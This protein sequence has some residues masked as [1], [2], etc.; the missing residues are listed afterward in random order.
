MASLTWR[1]FCI[2][3]PMKNV[4]YFL[5]AFASFQIYA[6]DTIY[7]C[8][9]LDT[10]IAPEQGL[11]F[12][13]SVCYLNNKLYTGVLVVN[14]I[15]DGRSRR[16]N[17]VYYFEN[18]RPTGSEELDRRIKLQAKESMSIGES[19]LYSF[20][21]GMR[22]E[23]G[24]DRRKT[25]SFSV[26]VNS[27]VV[28]DSILF[29]NKTFVLADSIQVVSSSFKF[30][31][32]ESFS[33]STGKTTTVGYLDVDGLRYYITDYNIGKYRTEVL[34]IYYSIN[35]TQRFCIEKEYDS[36]KSEAAP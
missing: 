4:I 35:G 5:F 22:K 29:E 33:G 26:N 23:F 13:D 32:G 3:K 2:L 14:C 20:S 28:I 36:R 25:S 12:K 30:Q 18:G 1:Y 24:G 21:G 11:I 31:V 7:S 27:S 9:K 34:R 6:Q 15:G 16:N 19:S 8:T 10:Y 17:G